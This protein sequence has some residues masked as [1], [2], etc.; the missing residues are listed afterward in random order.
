ML[1]TI[2]QQIEKSASMTA[3]IGFQK[4]SVTKE[5]TVLSHIIQTKREVEKVLDLEV[6]LQKIKE[7]R[8]K[9]M[10]KER[11]DRRVLTDLLVHEVE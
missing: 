6:H 10:V 5:T 8:G 9:E 2:P 1:A 7:L 11:N 4:E 3:G